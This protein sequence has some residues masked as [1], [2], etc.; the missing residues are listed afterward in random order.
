[1]VQLKIAIAF[2]NPAV[3]YRHHPKSF[4]SVGRAS[5]GRCRKAW[6]ASPRENF[7]STKPKL[8]GSIGGHRPR[9]GKSCRV[10]SIKWSCVWKMWKQ[11]V[12]NKPMLAIP[13]SKPAV[14]PAR[15]PS[16][17][18]LAGARRAQHSG[19]ASYRRAEIEHNPGYATP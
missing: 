8:R 19:S 6:E 16:P 3:R 2:T 18:E 7:P 5:N 13:E 9:R 11:A 15:G 10:T 14:K 12:A 1:M 4:V 17:A